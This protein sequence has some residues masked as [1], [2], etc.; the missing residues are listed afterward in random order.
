MVVVFIRIM[1]RE[2]P[3][4]ARGTITT[5]LSVDENVSC[6]AFL[7]ASAASALLELIDIAAEEECASVFAH[8]ALRKRSPTWFILWKMQI[9]VLAPVQHLDAGRGLRA[10]LGVPY[11]RPEG[12]A[13]R[14]RGVSHRDDQREGCILELKCDDSRSHAPQARLGCSLGIQSASTK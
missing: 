4:S 13:P 7:T 10:R 14:Q 1:A 6:G 5:P 8:F 11:R 12:P 3:G 2:A 9:T